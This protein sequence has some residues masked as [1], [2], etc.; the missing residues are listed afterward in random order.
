MAM[1]KSDNWENHS[2]ECVTRLSATSSDSQ[3]LFL[4]AF[5]AWDDHTKIVYFH[6]HVFFWDYIKI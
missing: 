2:T 3:K 6:G 4:S 1:V 5:S